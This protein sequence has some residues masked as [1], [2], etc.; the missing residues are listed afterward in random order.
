MNNK[1]ICITGP[2]GSGKST[3][4]SFI[5]ENNKTLEKVRT[6]T[7]RKKR[8]DH[9][10]Y[11]FVTQEEFTQMVN[12]DEFLEYEEVYGG[13]FY[14]SSISEID[15][16]W[17]KNKTPIL[18]LDIKGS[19][20]L[21]KMF[22]E[23]TIVFFLDAPKEDITQRLLL[24]GNDQN[25]QDRLNKL[26][27]ELGFAD[28][29]DYRIDTKDVWSSYKE[30]NDKIQR[31]IQNPL[32]SKTLVVNLYGGPGVSKSTTRAGLF[33]E[34][35]YNGINCEEAP[36]F[37]KDIVW[38]K[39]ISLLS[40]QIYL[41]G[42][43]HQRVHRLL[44]QVDVVITDSPLLMQISYSKNE[45]LNQLIYHEHQKLN[46]LNIFLNR[47]KKYNPSGRTQTEEQAREKDQ[48]IFKL[49]GDYQIPFESLD[50]SR[51][52][53]EPLFRMVMERIKQTN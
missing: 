4:A 37:A 24:R 27:F 29:F 22:G 21:K 30:I 1:I 12:S 5:L 38:S 23:K 19:V 42:E 13:T 32:I 53:I 52:S 14:G 36:E 28:Q 3:L 20:T 17:S 35:K 31:E 40:N 9:D 50:G 51:E 8:S 26:E 11:H 2:S 34:L 45:I 18:V 7:T 44:D 46:N 41:F 15:R 43:Q 25:V 16:I 48:E 39:S 49:L 47:V 6:H 33:A 10:D